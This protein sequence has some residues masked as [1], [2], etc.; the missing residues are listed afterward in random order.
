MKKIIGIIRPFD[1]K[2]VLYVYQDGNKLDNIQPTIDSMPEQVIQLAY[3]HEISQIDLSG[4]K[5]FTENIIKKIK[6][7]EMTKY[8]KN[9]LII[10]CI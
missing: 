3:K 10:K 8:N 7:R 4:P 1:V 9:E 2:Q 5:R 6:Q